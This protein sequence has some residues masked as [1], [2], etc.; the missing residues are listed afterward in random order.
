[1]SA[2]S[3][4]ATTVWSST[5]ITR[6]GFSPACSPSPA[7]SGRPG[8]GNTA[9]SPG[10]TRY[11]FRLIPVTTHASG[12]IPGQPASPNLRLRSYDLQL[13]RQSSGARH[14]HLTGLYTPVE[15]W[16]GGGD[17]I[18]ARVQVQRKRTLRVE[19]GPHI[20]LTRVREDDEHR[21]YRRV[22][23][24]ARWAREGGSAIEDAVYV[25]RRLS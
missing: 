8:E 6:I 16:R 19:L 11:T 23:W 24:I 13:Q 12:P 10:A 7:P 14:A 21:L 25:H 17:R 5:I 20:G 22:A 9:P 1:M 2:A 18:A 3:P 4:S 15:R